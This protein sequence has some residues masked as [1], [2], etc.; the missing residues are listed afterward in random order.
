MTK[1]TGRV[2]VFSWLWELPLNCV[3]K[4]SGTNNADRGVDEKKYQDNYLQ[5]KYSRCTSLISFILWYVIFHQ[6]IYNMCFFKG[7]KT[8]KITPQKQISI[9]FIYKWVKVATKKLFDFKR[10]QASNL[11]A[12][13]LYLRVAFPIFYWGNNIFL[14]NICFQG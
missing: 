4:V 3:Y 9:I 1:V 14:F 12:L 10:Y 5:R 11:Y 2:G 7:W 8:P 6:K 13:S